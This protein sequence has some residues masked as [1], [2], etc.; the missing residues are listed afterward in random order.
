ME[1]IRTSSVYQKLDTLYCVL[2]TI[3]PSITSPVAFYHLLKAM[4]AETSCIH[5]IIC[6]LQQKWRELLPFEEDDSPKTRWASWAVY[7]KSKE[8]EKALHFPIGFDELTAS[9]EED[10]LMEES[11]LLL[12]KLKQEL[13]KLSK[14]LLILESIV[15]ASEPDAIHKLYDD[16]KARCEDASDGS[17]DNLDKMSLYELNDYQKELRS[18]I[19]EKVILENR[20]E[21]KLR[22]WKSI[23]NENEIPDT[24]QA[25]RHIYKHRCKLKVH[26]LVDFFKYEKVATYMCRFH[27]KEVDEN[28][29]PLHTDDIINGKVD[30]EQ[31][32]KVIQTKFIPKLKKR[33]QWFC[34]WR[35]MKDAHILVNAATIKHFTGLIMQW[36]PKNFAKDDLKYYKDTYLAKVARKNWNEEKYIEDIKTHPKASPSALNNFDKLCLE[37]EGILKD[38]KLGKF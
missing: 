9:E 11:G 25:G 36:F 23:T 20:E 19:F 38:E 5:D 10:R 30:K 16:L 29:L 37:L 22:T 32:K 27:E 31:L 2:T 8:V 1:T 35:V 4:L 13:C 26:D 12:K 6:S 3:I 14:A 7:L 24:L 18:S 21:K 15:K 28:A 34:V 17:K 33:N